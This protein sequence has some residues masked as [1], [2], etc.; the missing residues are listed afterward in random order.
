MKRCT[1]G[2]GVDL[3]QIL[4]LGQAEETGFLRVDF[5]EWHQ[6]VGCSCS[7]SFPGLSSFSLRHPPMKECRRER[8]VCGD[9]KELQKEACV[10]SRQTSIMRGNLIC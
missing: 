8:L 1:E 7:Q 4:L 9:E 3:A 2:S 5:M 6:R 10:L